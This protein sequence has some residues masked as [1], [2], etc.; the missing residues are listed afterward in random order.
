[1]R[2]QLESIPCLTELPENY[3][4]LWEL[5]L[6][7]IWC[8]ATLA[9]W[10]ERIDSSRKTGI[11][12]TLFVNPSAKEREEL[13]QVFGFPTVALPEY[14]SIAEV[15]QALPHRF[16][17]SKLLKQS[18]VA[19]EITKR[20]KT[21]LP[22][23]ALLLVFDGLSFYDVIDWKFSGGRLEP[24]LVD[25]LSIT[26]HAMPRIVG[27]DVLTYRLFELGYTRRMGFSYWERAKNPLTDTLFSGFLK[28]Q[29]HRVTTFDEF[30]GKLS[31]AEFPHPTYL[32]IIRT[33]LDSV[34]HTHREK[35]NVP[36]LLDNLKNDIM[37][38][39][40]VLREIDTSFRLFITAD[41]GILWYTNQDVVPLANEK[42]KMRYTEKTCATRENVCTLKSHG[43]TYTVFLG[44]SEIARARRTTEWGFHGGISA[45]ESLVP[46][47]DIQ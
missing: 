10:R 4:A 24:C 42:Y 6:G 44:D 5:C 38:L 36:A 13:T 37:A 39:V 47:W 28:P 14:P 26:Q 45:Q 46:F 12:P 8:P 30:L 7:E 34:S 25:G 22:Q 17:T 9:E 40:D 29:L 11:A 33:G 23:I 41:H 21:E 31:E 1:M 35:P 43:S 20:L 18:R 27:S 32:Q 19:T 3:R 15:N 2:E 16:E